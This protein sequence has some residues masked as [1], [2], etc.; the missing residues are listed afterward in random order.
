MFMLCRSTACS[1]VD[2]L[3]VTITTLVTCAVSMVVSLGKSETCNSLEYYYRNE[4][5][6]RFAQVIGSC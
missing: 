6:D 2:G 5:N 1:I 4:H 3:E